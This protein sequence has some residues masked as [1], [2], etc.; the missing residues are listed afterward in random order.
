[1]KISVIAAVAQ[2]GVIGQNGDLPWED[3]PEDRS[4]F[5]KLTSGHVVIAG[6][7]T[8]ESIIKR[9]GGPLLGRTTI[10]LSRKL[11]YGLE[12]ASIITAPSLQ[13]ALE[14]ARH[15]GEEEV[16]VIGGAEVY[17]EALC[18]ADRVYLTMVHDFP[19]GDTF[20]PPFN[21]KK[22]GW[23][24]VDGK[25]WTERTPKGDICCTFFTYERIT[26]PAPASS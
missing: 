15:R 19:D 13:A 18:V 12:A 25:T 2:N 3:I 1:M 26:V 24:E 4:R 5:A 10:V 9:I 8:H 17:R 7:R 23:R 11:D 20:F 14:M 6:R 16:F 21:P 22:D